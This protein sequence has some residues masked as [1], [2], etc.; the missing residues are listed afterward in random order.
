M[1]IYKDYTPPAGNGGLFLKIEDGQTVRLRITGAPVVFENEYEGKLSTRYAWPVY[2][3]DEEKTQVFQGGATIYNAIAEIAQDDE[4]GDIEET[5]IKISRKGTGTD[6]KYA[7]T[8]CPKN[9]EVPKNEEELDLVAIIGKS[10]FSHNVQLLED[11]IKG[12][13]PAAKPQQDVVL[14]DIDDKPID[15]TDIPF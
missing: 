6:T 13:K 4:W 10:E 2:N 9:Q 3:H 7:V 12:A 1:N 8:P 14:E 15:L 11:R 5:D